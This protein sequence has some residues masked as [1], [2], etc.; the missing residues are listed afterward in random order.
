[1]TLIQLMT[2]LSLGLLFSCGS[3]LKVAPVDLTQG[4][5]SNKSITPLKAASII[6]YD[7]IDMNQFSEKIFILNGGEFAVQQT[8][9][10]KFFKEVLGFEDLQKRVIDANIQDKNHQPFLIMYFKLFTIPGKIIDDRYMQL[11]VSNSETKQ[12]VFIAQVK[13]NLTGDGIN[14]QNSRY[15]LFNA[16][17]D[18]IHKNK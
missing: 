5:I 11:V 10:F 1:L 4:L 7:Q 15:P 14:D 18:W 16:F 2:I 6:K 9:E 3:Q 17:F 12:D 8:K 13:W